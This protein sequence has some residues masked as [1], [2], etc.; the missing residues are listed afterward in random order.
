[1]RSIEGMDRGVK[2]RS[3]SRGQWALA[4]ASA[5]AAQQPPSGRLAFRIDDVDLEGHADGTDR[6]VDLVDPA[7][8]VET[9]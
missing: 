5:S 3:W 1:M 9:E 6:G 8:V 4:I 2:E 7:G